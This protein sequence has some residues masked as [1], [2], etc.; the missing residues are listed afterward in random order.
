MSQAAGVS[1]HHFLRTFERLTGVTPHQYLLRA[2][3]REAALGLASREDTIL[4]LQFGFGDHS[5]QAGC[6]GN[7]CQDRLLA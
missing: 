2:R 1:P 5:I 7:F 6:E 4:A 3:L